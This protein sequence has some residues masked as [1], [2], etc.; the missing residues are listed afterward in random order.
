MIT[1]HTNFGD[2][3]INTFAD[4]APAAVANFE[5]YCYKFFYENT[6]FQLF[7]NGLMIHSGVFSPSMQKKV[8]QEPIANEANNDLKNTR[9]TWPW[10]ASTIRIQLPHS[11]LLTWLITISSISVL[12]VQ[13]ARV[14]VCLPK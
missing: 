2:I 13:M 8:T 4:K 14:T 10:R 5:N 12:N 7:I 3:V 9:G 6:I 11:S 1:L